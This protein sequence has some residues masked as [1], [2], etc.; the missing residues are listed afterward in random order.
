MKLYATIQNENWKTASKGGNE[1]LTIG[2][3][4][5]NSNVAT[6]DFDG[7]EIKIWYE[8]NHYWSAKLQGKTQQ[9][10]CEMHAVKDCWHCHN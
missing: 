3:N 6:I 2:L 8:G 4:R 9:G 7:D 1:K 10:K 5:G